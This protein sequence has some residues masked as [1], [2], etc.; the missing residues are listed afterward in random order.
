MYYQLEDNNKAN[1]YALVPLQS[2]AIHAKLE[3]ALATINVELGYANLDS[4]NPIE[5]HFSLPIEQQT[6]VSKFTCNIDDRVIEA[7][8]KSKEEAKA[9]YD[10]GVAAGKAAVYAERQTKKDEEE[11]NIKLGNLLAG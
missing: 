7:K 10:D 9:Q 8:V 1:K 2:V 5:A 4:A 3:G 11:L 6:V